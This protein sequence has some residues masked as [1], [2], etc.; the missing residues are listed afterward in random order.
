MLCPVLDNSPQHQSPLKVSGSHDCHSIAQGHSRVFLTETLS[1]CGQAL[2]FYIWPP[3]GQGQSAGRNSQAG[4]G[5]SHQLLASPHF[6]FFFPQTSRKKMANW[7][8][9]GGGVSVVAKWYVCVWYTAPL[10]VNFLSFFLSF[11]R[12][13]FFV[14]SP[15]CLFFIHMWRINYGNVLF[16]WKELDLTYSWV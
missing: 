10:R 4:H 5:Q 9:G 12:W 6:D 1:Q 13:F 2:L 3:G 11:V 8:I 7:S 16:I 15:V 14:P